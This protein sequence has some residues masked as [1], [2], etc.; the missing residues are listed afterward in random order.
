MKSDGLRDILNP[1]ST[2][3]GC[4]SEMAKFWLQEVEYR[5]KPPSRFLV[6]PKPLFFQLNHPWASSNFN[7]IWDT[8]AGTRFRIQDE[9]TSKLV[10]WF[11]GCWREAIVVVTTTNG[12]WNG[13]LEVLFIFDHSHPFSPTG[14]MVTEHQIFFLNG[15]V[16]CNGWTLQIPY[17]NGPFSC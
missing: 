17:S 7:S 5:L 6:S 12:R 8:F 16:R 15:P 11:R 4:I 13:P 1:D 14:R 9:N 10:N 3:S 2:L